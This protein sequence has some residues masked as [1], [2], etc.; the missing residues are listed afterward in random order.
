MNVAVCNSP[1]VGW[2][3]VD[4][5]IVHLARPDGLLLEVFRQPGERGRAAAAPGRGE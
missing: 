5:S 3:D 1:P 4:L 2:A